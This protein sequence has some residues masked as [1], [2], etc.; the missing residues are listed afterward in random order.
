MSLDTWNE[1]GAVLVRN[2]LRTLLTAMGV[3]WGL[4]MLILML[5]F[6][7]GLESVARQNF[8]G[9]ATNS[10]FIWGG[11]T[12][13]AHAGYRPG[14]WIGFR[15]ADVP[16]LEEVRGLAFVAPRAQL[17]GWRNGNLVVHGTESGSYNIM[18]D[19]ARMFRI[20]TVD[21]VRGRVLNPLDEER[22]RKV[23]VI[24]E[25][26]QREL[27]GRKDPIGELIRV[28]GVYFQ[29]VGVVRSTRADDRGDRDNS[30]V[31]VPFTTYQRAFN[32][33]DRVSWLALMAEE[34]VPA[35][36]VEERARAVLAERHSV[37]PD[38][39]NAFGSWNAQEDVQRIENLFGGIRLFVW[40]VGVATL[41]SGVVG[42]S[43]IMLVVVRERTR[44]LGLRRALGATRSQIVQL[45]VVEAI[46]L[47]T[48]A[49]IF[50]VFGGVALVEG[51][52]WWLGPD[53]ETVGTPS[54][55]PLV[56]VAALGVLVVAGALAGLLPAR[57]AARIHPVEALRAE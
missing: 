29:V 4:L 35:G 5:G 25:Q 37:H 46:L 45:V 23:A 12:S 34:G 57:R 16:A 38:D 9:S 56:P 55:R 28:Q 50:G 47:T 43:N 13:L 22:Q 49:G 3:F 2:P 15:N 53:H 33:G 20:L 48:L 31:H 26:V 7:E 32:Q 14:R 1:I 11:R 54:V 19:V 36:L 8:A 41:L 52:A 40:I 51:V 30:T 42:V 44:E 39:E 21:L 24:G 18:G 17:G 10:V 27:F 6:G